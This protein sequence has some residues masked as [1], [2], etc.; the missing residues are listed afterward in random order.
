VASGGRDLHDLCDAELLEELR[1]MGG[2]PSDL[3]ED[4]ETMANLLPVLRADF[5]VLETYAFAGDDRLG[6][7][8]TAFRGVSDPCASREGTE[9]W[10]T[11]TSGRFTLKTYPG[12]H[13]FLMPHGRAILTE[14]GVRLFRSLAEVPA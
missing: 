11:L 4:A 8:I 7:D 9:A 5:E 14:A 13:F 1:Q 6:C 2:T 3:L 10:A 12:N